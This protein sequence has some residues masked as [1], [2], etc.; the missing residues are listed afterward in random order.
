MKKT[1]LCLILAAFLVIALYGCGHEHAYVS[2]TT[3]EATCEAE[4]TLTYTCE[5]GE[6]Y[7]E[8]ISPTDHTWDEGV[9]TK[10][11][12][13]KKEGEKTFTCT[14]C[15]YKRA[16]K[17]DKTSTPATGDNTLV[18]PMVILAVL[19]VCGLG[20]TAVARKRASR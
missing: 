17:I 19:S 8:A 5:C 7:T 3:L 15:E 10:K 9:I 18:I 4:G 6:S 20:V 12:T 14:T 2:E 16:E 13:N 11:P 1:V